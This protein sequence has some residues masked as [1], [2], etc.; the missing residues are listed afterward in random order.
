MDA[1]IQLEL[2]LMIDGHIFAGRQNR[3]GADRGR[4]RSADAI[5]GKTVVGVH[6]VIVALDVAVTSRNRLCR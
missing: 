5:N 6:I 3:V 1:R 2:R 4:V